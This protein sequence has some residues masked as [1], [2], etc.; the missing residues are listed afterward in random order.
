MDQEHFD[1]LTRAVGS[2]VRPRR[3]VLRALGGVLLSCAFGGV[4]ARLGMDDVTAA[5]ATK[6][7]AKPKHKR[8]LQAKQEAPGQ[9]RAAGKGKG[10]RKGKG[11][12]KDK[13]HDKRPQNPPPS[14]PQPCVHQCPNNG[15]C[16]GA[17]EC[18]PGEKKCPDRESPTGL[19][20][21]GAD[22]CCPDQKKCAG[23]CVYRQACCPEERPQCGPTEEV[24]CVNGQYECSPS[25]P[26][27]RP[28]PDGSCVVQGEC[29]PG[30]R[31][32]GGSICVAAGACCA[33]EQPCADGS[34]VAEEQCCPELQCGEGCCPD[35]MSCHHTG[36][37]CGVPTGG[38]Y[39]TCVC[40]SGYS[41]S[42]GC[43][44]YGDCCRQGCC[45]PYC[46]EDPRA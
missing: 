15:P 41:N 31:L 3:Q 44:A 1:D 14:P 8:R 22:D 39:W 30:E 26:N 9:L 25:C 36:T 5:K 11:K 37:C 42:P 28:C 20:C 21:L 23:G 16:V 7:Q 43:N 32:C 40:A 34:C 6:H 24:L 12:G 45:Y 27:G 10:R 29:C 17:S 13:H 19:S 35:G 33:G 4:A 38:T 46:C 18:C 2:G